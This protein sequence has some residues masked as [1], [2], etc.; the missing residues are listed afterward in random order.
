MRLLST[1]MLCGA[2]ALALLSGTSATAKSFLKSGEYLRND[3]MLVSENRAFFAYMQ[4]DGNFVVYKGT[5]FQD[6]YGALW[7]T[8]AQG[9]GQYFA[10]QQGDGNFAIYKGTGPADN[11][12]LVWDHRRTGANGQAFTI[13]QDSGN[14]C[15]YKGTGPSDNKGLLW[16]SDKYA[17][18]TW[19]PDGKN[20]ALAYHTSSRI[21][22]DARNGGLALMNASQRYAFRPDGTIRQAA[23]SSKCLRTE[24]NG[25]VSLGK[26]DGSQY[27][28]GWIYNP[29]DKSL[30]KANNPRAC[31]MS[32]NDGANMSVPT[33][34][35]GH[36]CPLE[37][38]APTANKDHARW[39]L[40]P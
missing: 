34:D 18:V 17:T 16:C 11:K 23:D 9:G 6:M 21:V 5:S 24:A 28:T 12:G 35:A 29:A 26:C 7:A 25:I 3:Q 38:P 1:M 14:L 10:I 27:A 36:L 2:T 33:Y 20:I 31:L 4:G 32:G 30:R 40:V 15:T 19:L 13:L 37:N 8:G 22:F 39:V